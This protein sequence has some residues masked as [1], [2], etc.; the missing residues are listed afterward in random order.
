M[1]VIAFGLVAALLAWMVLVAHWFDT[2]PV[3]RTI[4]SGGHVYQFRNFFTGPLIVRLPYQVEAINALLLMIPCL[5]G[6]LLGVPLVAGEL[7]DHTNR[8]AWTQGT[9]RTRWLTT[10]WWVIG[11]PPLVAVAAVVLVTRW[12]SHHVIGTG[13]GFLDPP[14]NDLPGFNQFSPTKPSVFSVTGIVPVTYTLFAFA[15]G[16]ALGPL[17]KRVSL[18][19]VG[20]VAI[21][22][23][24]LLV[25]VTTIRPILAPQTFLSDAPMAT[26]PEYRQLF[27]TQSDPWAIGT[28]FRFVPGFHSLPGASAGALGNHCNQ[29]DN[30]GTCYTSDHIEHGTYYQPASNF[31]KLQ[32]RES[33]IYLTMSVLLLGIGL[34]S[35]RR[36]RA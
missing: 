22:G 13:I 33:A 16:T 29:T 15:L 35:V 8:L 36:W 31:W 19:A 18:A 2:T 30:A 21:Y 17:A 9:S 7:S 34:F 27:T 25:M 5:L 11:L 10:K 12:W 23:F 28:G 20:T 3:Q 6:V 14:S 26:S 24:A 1:L 32:W 4:E